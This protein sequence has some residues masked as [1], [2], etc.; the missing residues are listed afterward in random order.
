[1]TDALRRWIATG[2][3]AG[4]IGVAP[5]TVGALEGLALAWWLGRSGGNLA[6]AA[7]CIVVSAA[8]LWA[9]AGAER[10]F[11]EHDPQRVVVDEIAGQML[12]L[13]FLPLDAAGLIVS[14]VLFRVFDIAK[15]FPLRR[16][17]ALPGGA[18]I[19]ADDLAAGLYA[20]L[21]HQLLRAGLAQAWGAR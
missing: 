8:G 12:S 19:M 14:F 7:G 18:G 10:L 21:V 11:G 16:L 17:E 13:L 2:L 5:G 20:N 6:L 3:G 9:A 15:P 4:H 1:M